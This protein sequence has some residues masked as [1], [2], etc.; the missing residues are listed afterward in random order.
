MIGMMPSTRLQIRPVLG[1]AA[2][3]IL[4]LATSAPAQE[5]ANPLE[6]PDTTGPRET[7][8]SFIERIDEM[9]R[10][11]MT[12]DSSYERRLRVRPKARF[13]LQCFDLSELA[14]ST[15]ESRAFQAAIYLKEVFDR[16]EMPPLEE[17]PDHEAVKADPIKRFRIPGTEITLVRVADGPR[18]GEYLF[19]ADTIQRAP[20]FFDRVR[21]LPYRQEAT[22]KGLYQ[23]YVSLQGWLVPMAWVDS[24]PAWSRTP[25]LEQELWHWISL[26]AVGLLAAIV[27]ARTYRVGRRQELPAGRIDLWPALLRFLF[28]LT[29]I[30]ATLLIDFVFSTQIRFTGQPLIVLK[31][32][33]RMQMLLAG[34]VAVL[35]ALNRV[36]DLVIHAKQMRP[37]GLDG[38]LVR[39]GFRLLTFL[40]V[41]WLV[42]IGAEYL[43]IPVTPLVAGLGVSGLAVALAAQYT[44]ENLIA[45]LVLFAD[46]PV[47][48][49]DVCR[50]GENLGTVEQ[51]GLRSTRIRAADRTVIAVPNAEFAK[52]HL[53]NYTRRDSILL[54]TVLQLRYETTADQL[55]YVLVR[56]RELLQAHPQIAD[57]GARVRFVGYGASSLDVELHAFARTSDWSTFLAIQ[58][59]VLLRI[60]DV[61]NEA[62]SGFAF[63]AQVEYQAQD[64][65]IDAERVRAAE[66]HVRSMRS[67]GLLA[68]AGFAVEE[69]HTAIP[70]PHLPPRATPGPGRA[71]SRFE[72]FVRRN[73]PGA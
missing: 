51:I 46:K 73:N 11:A 8:A 27:V 62:G 60:M 17:L 72:G 48:V 66:D 36:A 53:V 38:Q 21:S 68:R 13:L 43:G 9:F 58:E 14:P 71:A 54:K 41:A 49:G 57:D 65:A 37:G 33:L 55:R 3:L 59:D 30:G 47:R 22:S 26:A 15:A 25:V 4:G 2:A 28:P 52:L 24:L 35:M 70:E 16:I 5:T 40:L 18:E 29:W 42:V 1:L 31:V 61:V 10:I 34:I 50:F 6:P 63:P 12:T 67:D 23:M 20:E 56:L 64:L 19:S 45:G 44:I 39:L 7:I 32:A 69:K